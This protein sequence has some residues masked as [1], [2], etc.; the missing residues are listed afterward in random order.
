MTVRHYR[1]PALLL[2]SLL[3]L[4]ACGKK[5]GDSK[6]LATVNGEAITE[7][8]YNNYVG[9]REAEHGP[10]PNKEMEKKVVLDE[11]TTRMLLAQGAVDG[12][13]DREPDVALQLKLQRENLLARAM[14]RS[15]LRDNPISDEEVKKRF[16]D[17][18]AKADKNEYRARHILVRTEEEAREILT[19]LQ[20]GANF[21]TLA[22]QKSVDVRSGKQ[23]GRLGDWVNQDMLVPDFFKAMSALKKGETTREPVKTDYGW[24]IIRLEESRPR[25]MPVF[26]QARGN[27][28]QMIQQE[29]VD[30][31]VKS[32]RDK[33]KIKIIE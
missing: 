24:H 12:K 22:E 14:L 10:F 7:M 32:Q 25:K 11:I 27:V 26:D 18:L 19:K 9:A 28:R 20:G 17:N 30:A 23:G 13:V 31:L 1:F 6:V 21:A 29:R 2:A 5:E 3:A 16:D 33:S 15:Y 4:A 8:E